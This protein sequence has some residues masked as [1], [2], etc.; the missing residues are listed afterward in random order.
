MESFE[1]RP[2]S[3]LGLANEVEDSLGKYGAFAIETIGGDTQIIVLKQVR[4]DDRFEGAPGMAG[5]SGHRLNP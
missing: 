5:F 4:L 2:F 1:P 3:G